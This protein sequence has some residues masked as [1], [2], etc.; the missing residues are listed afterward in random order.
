M[1]YL[2]IKVSLKVGLDI[3]KEPTIKTF[4]Y[5]NFLLKVLRIRI[6]I[7]FIRFHIIFVS[8]ICAAKVLNLYQRETYVPLFLF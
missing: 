4:F 6:Q 3:I 7:Q 2:E 8:F 1:Y 5:L